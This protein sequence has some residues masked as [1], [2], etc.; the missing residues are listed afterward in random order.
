MAL[1]KRREE[2]QGR[3]NRTKRQENCFND[4]TGAFSC[5]SIKNVSKQQFSKAVTFEEEGKVRRPRMTIQGK[6]I[7]FVV[8]KI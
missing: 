1:A 8:T 5:T 3:Q 7:K 6:D 2:T 4:H